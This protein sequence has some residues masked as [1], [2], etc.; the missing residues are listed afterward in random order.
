VRLEGLGQVKNSR[1][2]SEVEYATYRLV[3]LCLNQLRYSA[4]LLHRHLNVKVKIPKSTGWEFESRKLGNR[5]SIIPNYHY[6][7]FRKLGAVSHPLSSLTFK[8]QLLGSIHLVPPNYS[9]AS[10]VYLGQKYL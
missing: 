1:T 10:C 9:N 5:F 3:A 4:T 6:R 2:S 8:H 7:P